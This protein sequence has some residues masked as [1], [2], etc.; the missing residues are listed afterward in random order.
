MDAQN[1]Q[2]DIKRHGG[3]MILV[4]YEIWEV[5]TMEGVETGK[6]KYGELS[7]SKEKS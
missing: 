6:H 5:W 3:E 7:R 4:R 1:T 2:L